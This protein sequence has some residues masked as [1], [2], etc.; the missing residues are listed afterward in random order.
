MEVMLG[1][2]EKMPGY[3]EGRDWN[4]SFIS[5]GISETTKSYIGYM[6]L[7]FSSLQRESSRAKF[8]ISDFWSPRVSKRIYFCCGMPPS[9]LQKPSKTNTFALLIPTSSFIKSLKN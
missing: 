2:S 4:N 3:N 9:M 8:L 5:Q 7:S 6:K 1:N